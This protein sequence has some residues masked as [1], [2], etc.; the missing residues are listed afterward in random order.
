[1]AVTSSGPGNW[2]SVITDGLSV[3]DDVI[4]NHDVTLDGH[5]P[6]VN[7]L[8]INSGKTLTGGGYK[9]TIDGENSSG[10]AITNDGS[11]SGNLDL[12]INTNGTTSLNIGGS[13]G[14][15]FRDLKINTANTVLHLY[16]NTFIDGQL[17]I[18]A[19]QLKTY[20]EGNADKTLTCDGSDISVASGAFLK[21]KGSTVTSR[22]LTSSGT[23]DGNGGKFVVTGAG[24]GN[25]IRTI[26][27]GGSITGNVDVELTG[28]G[29]N[30][31]ED[32]KSDT[33]GSI[34]NLTINNAAAVVKTGRDTII[35]G[36]LEVTA[37][38]FDTENF[39]FECV[40]CHGNGTVKTG[41]GTYTATNDWRPDNTQLQVDG[42]TFTGIDQLGGA[43]DCNSKQVTIGCKR[44]H[45]SI[46]MT[47]GTSLVSDNSAEDVI[48][49]ATAAE[50]NAS[51]YGPLQGRINLVTNS[52]GSKDFVLKEDLTVNG[53]IVVSGSGQ[54]RTYDGSN[55]YDL[56][57]DG[58]TFHSSN[59]GSNY[60]CLDITN[61][62]KF[63]SG[64]SNVILDA[65]LG[66]NLC[67]VGTFDSGTTGWTA[68]TDTTITNDSGAVKIVKDDASSDNKGGYFML[69]ASTLSVSELTLGKVYKV[70]FDAK[71]NSGSLNIK[72]TTQPS[73]LPFG[74]GNET[75][76]GAAGNNTRAEAL[77]ATSYEKR[78]AY[79]VAGYT[80]SVYLYM[81]SMS[82][83]QILHIDNI[84]CQE[85]MAN[86]STGS[87]GHKQSYGL[88]VS[89]TSTAC[90]LGTGFYYSCGTR[91]AGQNHTKAS[92]RFCAG[93]G[94]STEYF[95]GGGN[96]LDFNN[97][98]IV[99]LTNTG[100][101]SSIGFNISTVTWNLRGFYFYASNTGHWHAYWNHD[102]APTINSPTSSTSTKI[103][104]INGDVH[105]VRGMMRTQYPSA[106]KYSQ[107][108]VVSGDVKVYDG[109]TLETHQDAYTSGTDC[110]H[111]FG[112]LTVD[113]GGTY[114]ATSKTAT[115]TK[116]NGGT[117]GRAFYI[118]TGG[119]FNHDYGLHKFTA[120][121]PQVAPMSSGQTAT[122]HPFYDLEQTSGT[123]QWKAEHHRVLRNA[124]MKG[125]AFNGS[126]G[127]VHVLGICRL[128]GE[129]FN[130]GD[131][132]TNN[133]NF[134]QTLIVESGA[135]LDLSAIDITVGSLRNKG[136][137][138]Q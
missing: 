57:V 9:I 122:S 138:I 24:L 77:S 111:S 108:L 53:R 45:S 95:S 116:N 70:T 123:I 91:F 18:A 117:D 89:S 44:F 83:G 128:T 132:A 75:P 84:T 22:K 137:T 133:N 47:N 14:N 51:V 114:K 92:G 49:T 79:F 107:G 98:D 48:V 78:V 50:S 64:S 10:F 11:I 34:R 33:A 4:I 7:S 46:A 74:Q 136:G 115:I 76:A 102:S 90:D 41:S 100:A 69:K 121:S 28:A 38:V 73:S 94:D 30:R 58:A 109:G 65:A 129:T 16:T 105:V 106:D 82:T 120:S 86:G 25:T 2:S 81:S 63:L 112:S 43:F 27:L 3:N 52:S 1:M 61:S 13:A 55:T 135:T 97:T 85:V 17:T 54:F 8:V 124:T 40:L 134:F 130:S 103:H 72:W 21:I 42:G 37:G 12:E 19:G 99:L 71:V 88:D 66:S 110:D 127:N 125:S 15:C 39:D 31:T 26:D 87:A 126:T 6:N 131:T 68:Y 104:T 113:S 101:T 60:S 5:A 80:T 23:L 62:A 56:L 36:N 93:S 32:L 35:S 29:N 118:H 96:A 59:G 119:T 67:D 20:S